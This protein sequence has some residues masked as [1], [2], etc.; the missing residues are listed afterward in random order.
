MSLK[1]KRRNSTENNLTLNKM[2][3]ANI[4]TAL[5]KFLKFAY[6]RFWREKYDKL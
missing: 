2:Q 6:S 1:C 5:A 4:Q 3:E